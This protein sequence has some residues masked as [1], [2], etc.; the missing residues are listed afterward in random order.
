MANVTNYDPKDVT[1]TID[2]IYITGLG[3]DMISFEFDEERFSTSVGAQGDVVVNE[4]HNNLATMT[5]S[6]QFTS[7]QYSTLLKYAKNGKTFPVWAVNKTV[8]ERCGGTKA[9]FKNPPEIAYGSEHE[10]RSFEIAVFDGIVE[11]AN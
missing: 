3:E 9:R 6:V 7:P 11:P 5:I 2:G 8:G 4:I 1:L 10:D